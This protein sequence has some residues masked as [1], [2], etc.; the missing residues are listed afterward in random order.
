VIRTRRLRH[1]CRGIWQG[2]QGAQAPVGGSINDLFPCC[3]GVAWQQIPPGERGADDQ[4]AGWRGGS[5]PRKP[6]RPAAA[7]QFARRGVFAPAAHGAH[8]A[9]H[10][11]HPSY[12]WVSHWAAAGGGS[13]QHQ[14]PPSFP[15]LPAAR[16]ATLRLS[17]EY[18][19]Y[20]LTSLSCCTLCMHDNRSTG[21]R[22]LL[23]TFP[24]THSSF[25]PPPSSMSSGALKSQ[26]RPRPRAM[27]RPCS[28]CA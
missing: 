28:G 17:A 20:A 8:S 12:S 1:G 4:H 23:W 6:R 16:L 24:G 5:G 27:W 18:R 3:K 15:G 2:A 11:Q 9:A 19:G 25:L 14:S 21:L 10:W 7:I 22:I 26:W 13:W